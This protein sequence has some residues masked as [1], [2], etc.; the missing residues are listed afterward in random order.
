M[1]TAG[2]GE[3]IVKNPRSRWSHWYARRDMRHILETGRLKPARKPRKAFEEDTLRET[4]RYILQNINVQILA[5][6]TRRLYIH[7]ERRQFS[8]II[9]KVGVEIL[10]SCYAKDKTGFPP[11]VRKVDRTLFCE[12]DSKLTK[13][14]VE[15]RACVD[16]KLHGL[17]YEN[18]NII[19]RIIDDHARDV[20]KRKQLKRKLKGVGE[21][22]KYSFIKHL[23]VTSADPMH[24]IKYALDHGSFD[25]D[26]INASC[27]E[28]NAV[29]NFLEEVKESIIDMTVNIGKMLTDGATKFQLF[30]GHIV[31]K[32]VQEDSI[33][34]KFEWLRKGDYNHLVVVNIDFKM[35]VEP[36]DFRESGI[37]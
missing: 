35:K 28:C 21:F 22:L 31:R 7:G 26:C 29:F 34:H 25:S 11:T 36:Q 16:Y 13:G 1:E 32:K 15:Q 18:S 19:R 27:E 5:W 14:D 6:S 23:S 37:Q 9:R 33:C 30:M 24:K 8:V 17:V 10:W 12:L 3:K 20:S 4:V 2:R